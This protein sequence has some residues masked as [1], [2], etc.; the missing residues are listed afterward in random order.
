MF[1][2]IL[3]DIAK[4]SV[5]DKHYRFQDCLKW[6]TVD[7]LFCCW[8]DVKK[9]A[10]G[11]AKKT[12]IARYEDSLQANIMHLEQ[13]VKQRAYMPCSGISRY[14]PK[15]GGDNHPLGVCGINDNILQLAVSR[16]LEAIYQHDF[17]PDC[18]GFRPTM[19]THKS[20]KVLSG[21]LQTGK[22]Q[23]LVEADIKGYTKDVNH[24]LLFEMLGRRIDDR[25]FLNLINKWLKADTEHSADG[26]LWHKSAGIKQGEYISPILGSIYLHHLLDLWLMNY[27]RVYCTGHTYF[28]R[29][30]HDIGCAF[31]HSEE[32]ERLYHDLS[33]RLERFGLSHHAKLSLWCLDAMPT[34]SSSRHL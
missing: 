28:S 13:Q 26:K 27:V 3:Q 32:A 10:I 19:G 24:E 12:S 5:Q 22:Y 9:N 6:L 29:Y 25:S 18:H 16:I 14:M 2:S 1:E 23:R 33:Y 31:Q 8:V 11:S 4:K 34:G 20:V 15:Q 17:L 21:E 30:S 7:C